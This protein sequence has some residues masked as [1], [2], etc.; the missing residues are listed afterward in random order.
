MPMNIQCDHCLCTWQMEL[1]PG[2]GKVVY[3][4]ACGRPVQIPPPQQSSSSVPP[5]FISAEPLEQSESSPLADPLTNSDERTPA[6][7]SDSESSEFHLAEDVKSTPQTAL[8]K[9]KSGGKVSESSTAMG[10]GLPSSNE[11]KRTPRQVVDT[12]DFSVNLSA[13]APS[14]PIPSLPKVSKSSS[15]NAGNEKEWTEDHQWEAFLSQD[16]DEQKQGLAEDAHKPSVAKSPKESEATANN[17]RPNRNRET[18][19]KRVSPTIPTI[20]FGQNTTPKAVEIPPPSIATPSPR[21]PPPLPSSATETPTT[22]TPSV[23]GQN[24]SLPPT[25]PVGV[26]PASTNSKPTRSV[27][28]VVSKEH[29]VEANV[30]QSGPTKR[31]K[32]PNLSFLSVNTAGTSAT[33]SSSKPD[34]ATLS[35]VMKPE[36]TPSTS[37]SSIL[38]NKRGRF[39]RFFRKFDPVVLGAGTLVGLFV[40]IVL[41]YFI[42][43]LCLPKKVAVVENVESQPVVS[44][45]KPSRDTKREELEK[46]FTDAELTLP[47]DWLTN[48]RC[49]PEDHSDLQQLIDKLP[50]NGILVISKGTQITKPFVIRKPMRLVGNGNTFDTSVL[51]GKDETTS[52]ITVEMPLKRSAKELVERPSPAS[53]CITFQNLT[54][55]SNSKTAIHVVEGELRL[56]NCFVRQQSEAAHS[57]AVCCDTQSFVSMD[58]CQFESGGEAIYLKSSIGSKVNNCTIVGASCGVWFGSSKP[59][60]VTT[61]TIRQL[62][63]SNVSLGIEFIGSPN[64]KVELVE[65]H[66]PRSAGMVVR[67]QDRDPADASGSGVTGASV[68][69]LVVQDSKMVLNESDSRGIVCQSGNIDLRNVTLECGET[70]YGVEIRGGQ[71]LKFDN[72][73]VR[74]SK[75]GVFCGG[76]A[77]AQF[78]KC[79]FLG[80]LTAG[81]LVQCAATKYTDSVT[82]FRGCTFR[83]SR[84]AG[85]HLEN[86]PVEFVDCTLEA[87][88]NAGV[89]VADGRETTVS[90]CQFLAQKGD[91]PGLLVAAEK[92]NR[93]LNASVC[94][95]IGSTFYDLKNH[96]IEVREGTVH[97]RQCT[98]TGGKTVGIMVCQNGAG[99]FEDCTVQAHTLAGVQVQDGGSPRFIRCQ[100]IQNQTNGALIVKD[101]GDVCLFQ[102]CRFD[103]NKLTGVEVRDSGGDWND[104]FQTEAKPTENIETPPHSAEASSGTVSGTAESSTPTDATPPK[105]APSE[106]SSQIPSQGTLFLDCHIDR[107]EQSG[108]LCTGVGSRPEFRSCFIEGN[109]RAGVVACEEA[110]VLVRSCTLTSNEFGI[111]VYKKG[112]GSVRECKFEQIRRHLYVIE[113]NAGILSRYKNQPSDE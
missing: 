71:A 113:K 32:N 63:I 54:I 73:E 38:S 21:L 111:W 25:V 78:T 14:I 34:L 27:P 87:N 19:R 88:L 94:E 9:E 23:T 91:A 30:P 36:S 35:D 69:V 81:A 66:E 51:Q 56:V 99:V 57:V 97:V 59:Q 37:S 4:P 103:S 10:T 6:K 108:V 24:T 16:M 62:K 18:E 100:F 50:E 28:P 33:K 92:Q 47:K 5:S 3:C 89:L 41:A 61:A 31:K 7:S 13:K 17:V 98:F 72:L 46:V 12:S 20:T 83:D 102:T 65:I 2:I 86:G 109:Q 42:V 44:V 48:V 74:G 8:P 107:N 84:G 112:G 101:R 68:P 53:D 80:S 90:R 64:G 60:A 79:R 11:G 96:G 22:F 55:S 49:Y 52:L 67:T 82:Q 76:R 85:V 15:S 45:A 26:T 110:N 43:P 104:M 105:D 77:G 40:L 39:S 106:T 1:H 93:E 75:V 70:R 58:K 95:V 29:A